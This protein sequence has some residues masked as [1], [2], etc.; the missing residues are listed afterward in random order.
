MSIFK[1][2]FRDFVFEQLRIREAIMKKGNAGDSRFASIEDFSPRTEI[3][4]KDGK[5]KKITIDAGAF[6]TNTTS[7]QCVIRMCSGV[8][9]KDDEDIV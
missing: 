1:E 7:K 2:T 5:S 3:K 9:I 6:Y 8:D 4:G